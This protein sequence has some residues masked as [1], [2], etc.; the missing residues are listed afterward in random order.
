MMSGN[1]N[2]GNHGSPIA[3]IAALPEEIRPF[4][5]RLPHVETRQS[6]GVTLREGTLGPERVVVAVTGDGAIRAARSLTVILDAVRPRAILGVGIA[7]ALTPGLSVGDLLVS[8][9][10]CAW[11]GSWFEPDGELLARALASGPPSV[12]GTVV[13]SDRILVNA[14]ERAHVGRFLG[15][16][17]EAAV[18]MESAEWARVATDRGTPWLVVRSISETAVEDLPDYLPKCLRADGS[19]SRLR[20]VQRAGLQPRS[21]PAL[22]EMRRRLHRS[23]I[24][25]ADYLQMFLHRMMDHPVGR[26]LGARS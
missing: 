17:G 10:V 6:G 4:L 16:S 11:R 1:L 26:A 15:K 18:D 23:G 21:I 7:G 9:R 13:T 3:V 20:V 24:A 14:G 8:E 19:L 22:I 25:L 5:R 12:R 2:D